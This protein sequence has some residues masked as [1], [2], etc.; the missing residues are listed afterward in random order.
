[1]AK[2]AHS[3]E[4]MKVNEAVQHLAEVNTKNIKQRVYIYV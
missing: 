4:K 1:M 2:E 3:T